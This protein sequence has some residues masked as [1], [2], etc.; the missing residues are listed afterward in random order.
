MFCNNSLS[1]HHLSCAMTVDIRHSYLSTVHDLGAL[2][3]V[4]RHIY[5]IMSIMCDIQQGTFLVV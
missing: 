3:S 5:Y 1:I 2:S 4:I